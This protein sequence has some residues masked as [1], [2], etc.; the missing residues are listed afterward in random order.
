VSDSNCGSNWFGG[1]SD[2]NCGIGKDPDNNCGTWN[3]SSN[4]GNCGKPSSGGV[5]T[6]GPNGTDQDEACTTSVVDN[7]CS[8]NQVPNNGAGADVDGSCGNVY[9]NPDESCGDCDD[10]HQSDEHCGKPIAGGKDPD[11]LCGHQHYTEIF[12][13]SQDGV[14]STTESDAGCGAHTTQYGGTWVD[15]DQHCSGTTGASADRNCSTLSNDDTCAALSNPS[16]TSPDENC[17]LSDSDDACSRYDKDESCS[18]NYSKDDACGTTT[19]KW[20]SDPID[21]DENCGRTASDPDSASS[22]TVCPLGG[23]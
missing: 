8:I 3:S 9:M 19:I 6:G 23:G 12:G 5:S 14:C 10:N 1:P 11:D 20:V 22:T 17:S 4:D 2:A 15:P 16:T 13:E 7:N 18:M 21:D